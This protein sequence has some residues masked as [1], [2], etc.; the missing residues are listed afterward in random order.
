VSPLLAPY[1]VSDRVR[2]PD[3]SVVDRCSIGGRSVVVADGIQGCGQI[4]SAI[5]AKVGAV[6]ELAADTPTHPSGRLLAL[7]SLL[8]RRP[9]WSGGEL[10]RRLD[11]T[12]RTVRRDVDRLRELGYFVD[13][14]PG[15]EGGY[16]LEGGANMP[17]LLFDDDEATAAALALRSAATGPVMGLEE[18]SLAALSKLDRV[19]P[20]HLRTRVDSIRRATVYL[21]PGEQAVDP[22]LLIV[23]ARA[24]A[25]AERLRLD[26]RDRLDRV[27]E[28]RIEPFRL[29][30]TGRRWYLVACDVDRVDDE[31]GGWRTFRVDRIIG[32][33]PTGH[34]F[35]R[36]DAPDPAAFVTRAI[37]R[38]PNEQTVV[39]RFP[40]PLTTLE[41]VIPA[42]VGTMEADGAEASVLTTSSDN[43]FQTAGHLVGTGLPFEV[44]EPL[45]LREQ[46]RVL[47]RDLAKRH[48]SS[49]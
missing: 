10:A 16:R 6:D 32:L 24:S 47:A 36:G 25:E 30:C 22:E 49:P 45:E 44:V 37:T 39:V 15:P 31:E 11:V 7:L 28:R 40:T 46:V 33:T 20:P 26:Y 13:A 14:T 1:V 5:R 8:Q 4:R 29:V 9:S 12:P 41:S 27:T 43:V 38:T 21:D 42:W 17:P 34:R 19:M 3:W 35:H 18:A 48:R 2:R 23:A